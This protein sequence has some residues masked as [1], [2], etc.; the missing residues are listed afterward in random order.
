MI[1]ETYID[2]AM[3]REMGD[4][5]NMTFGASD[6]SSVLAHLSDELVE[7]GQAIDTLNASFSPMGWITKPHNDFAEELA[8]CRI[9]ISHFAHKSGF[10]LHA[11]LDVVEPWMSTD[12]Y[13]CYLDACELFGVVDRTRQPQ[14]ARYLCVLLH[15]MAQDYGVD[16]KA[17]VEKKFE[18][19]KSRKW[20]VP[21]ER[22]VVRHVASA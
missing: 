1:Q 7:L 4:W 20:G 10:V 9:F 5:A 3:Q 21:D 8:D 17:E 12:G 14:A 13:Q 2:G 18:K 16:L 11:P 6:A 19:N 22:G 15:L